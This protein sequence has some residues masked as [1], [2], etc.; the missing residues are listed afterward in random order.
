MRRLILITLAAGL[1]LAGCRAPKKQAYKQPQP[2]VPQALPNSQPGSGVA[3]AEL[4]WKDFFGDDKLRQVVGLALANNRDLRLAA[5]NVEKVQAQFRLQRAAQFPAVNA[6]ANASAYRVP[7]DATSNNQGYTY[8]NLQAGLLVS[9]WELDL[10][11]RVRSLKEAALEQYLATQQGRASTQMA[12]ISSVAGSYLALAA[13][14]D[15]LELA[16]A[17]L[18]ARKSSLDLISRSRDYGMRTDLDVSQARSLV[19][20]AEVDVVRYTA[21]ITLDENALNLLAGVQ[22]PPELL[23]A[24]LASID[25]LKDVS[26]GL[27]SDVLLRRPDILQAEH[28]LRAAYANIS[29]ARAAY[30]PRILLT[31]GGGLTSTALQRLFSFRALTWQFAPQVSV[32]IFDAGIRDANYQIA[33][34]TRDAYVAEYEKAIQ[35]AFRE[36]SDALSQRARLLEQEQAQTALVAT[37]NETYRLSEARYKGGIDGYLS[38]LDAQRS[39]YTGQQALLGVRLSRLTNLVTLYKVLGGGAQ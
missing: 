4:A 38:V 30:F 39:L 14:R 31:G 1:L 35:T 13:D 10:F 23:P 20:A 16:K 12:L 7:G 34:V 21:Q 36:T 18:E 25:S 3:P 22:V 8:E 11:G 33:Q 5:L 24:K 37:L 9:S 2:P 17:T 32:P 28:Q 27:S 19:Q 6:A 29:A 15:S 26:A